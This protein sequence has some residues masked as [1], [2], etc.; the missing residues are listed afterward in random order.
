M[1]KKLKERIAALGGAVIIL[2]GCIGCNKN[3]NKKYL[4]EETP[5]VE[6]STS[7]DNK[8][9]FHYYN[10]TVDVESTVDSLGITNDDSYPY[11]VYKVLRFVDK[12]NYERIVITK[13][14]VYFI[15]DENKKITNTVYTYRDAFTGEELLVTNDNIGDHIHDRVENYL[16][17]YVDYIIYQGDLLDLKKIV[18]EKGLNSDYANSIM[19]DD[20]NNKNLSLSEVG[21]MYVQLVNS[22]NRMNY[23]NQAIILN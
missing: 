9:D 21:R 5:T 3:N 1:E 16:S 20:I 18:I 23:S 4:Y 7:L 8:Y 19:S 6:Y 14:D 13:C 12:D 17:D 15:T 11:N 2:T 22:N 10:D